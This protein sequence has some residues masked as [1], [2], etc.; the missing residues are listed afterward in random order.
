MNRS[1]PEKFEL[2]AIN[3]L[4]EPSNA[5]PVISDGVL[6][7]DR[8]LYCTAE[9]IRLLGVTKPSRVS[10]LVEEKKT[11]RSRRSTEVHGMFIYEAFRFW[12]A[13]WKSIALPLRVPPRSS[14]FIPIRRGS[15]L[16]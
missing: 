13:G 15:S 16:R 3:D 10:R 6:R 14:V 5:R 11:R 4:G 9:E 2:V 12:Q 8:G 1:D 7:V